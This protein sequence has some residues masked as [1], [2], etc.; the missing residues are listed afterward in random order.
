M[1]HSLLTLLIVALISPAY[2]QSTS[3]KNIESIS[4]SYRIDG[5]VSVKEITDTTAMKLVSKAKRYVV[6]KSKDF[7]YIAIRSNTSTILNAYIISPTKISIL[8]AS[9]ALG[10]VDMVKQGDEYKPTQ[11][12]FDWIY[13]DPET[14]DEKHPDGVDSI[15]AFYQRF[16]WLANTWHSGSYREF[17]MI[18][19][20]TLIQDDRLLISY[21]SIEEGERAIRF[22]EGTNDISISGSKETDDQLHNGYIPKSVVFEN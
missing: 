3:W 20:N 1:K 7:T 16:G 5:S 11:A 17:E 10:Q 12:E 18:I 15:E 21:S 14:W 8:H 6:K 13:R 22:K 19:S 4:K 9:A 2:G